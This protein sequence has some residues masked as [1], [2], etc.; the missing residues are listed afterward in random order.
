MALA[1]AAASTVAFLPG[2]FDRFVWPKVLCGVLAVAVGFCA[3]GEGR[4]P[5]PLVAL[6]GTGVAVM[7][8]AA[9]AGGT[10]VA[11]LLGRWPRY[12]GVP[13]VLLY[14]AMTA[15][16]AHLLGGRDPVRVRVLCRSLTVVAVLIA[17]VAWA[18]TLGAS[19]L[20]RTDVD[21]AGG[22][23]GNATDQG[24]VALMIASVLVLPALGGSRWDIVG[25]VAALSVVAVSG[26]RAVYLA[27][28]V[29]GVVLAIAGR[30]AG[31]TRVLALGAAAVAAV[32]VAVPV[33]RERFLD[34]ATFA[35]RR[36]LWDDSIPLALEHPALGLGPSRYVDLIDA[37][38]GSAWLDVKDASGGPPDSPH[39]WVLQAWNA[40][41]VV[42]AALAVAVAG[43]VVWRGAIRVRE[44]PDDEFRAGALA[45]VLA[46]GVVL[47]THFT[48]AGTTLLACFLAGSLVAVDGASDVT[49]NRAVSVVAG[50]VAPFV[51]L[52]AAAD[53]PLQR[54]VGA[55][56]AGDVTG[57]Q[58][59][60]EL[61]A[62]LRWWDGDVAML[63]AQ[64]MA[65]TIATGDPRSVP[66][67]VEWADR[68]LDSTP[69]TYA[70][71]LA[72]AV[73]LT[74]SQRADEAI[75][76]LDD[77]VERFP[78]R[79]D[80]RVQRAIARAVVGDVT[81]ARS[82]LRAAKALDPDD[83]AV[84]RLQSALADVG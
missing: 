40:G 65:G 59:G 45:A 78:T 22:L 5:R 38:L 19:P 58:D 72:K 75:G 20:G 60:F 69:E 42:L 11:S 53:L 62:G 51:V 54:G 56:A 57:A 47:S 49:V 21:R 6:V 44:T 8:V 16:G 13:V 52:A 66:W 35:V 43:L 33:V 1:F 29:A 41:G 31:T 48:V 23:L 77:L 68:S 34:S 17:V 82:D 64:A 25:V 26:S 50:L 18:E 73:A 24:L 81:G 80:P 28:I 84:R 36:V 71:G 61:A 63:A 74:S 9:V 83:P 27:T 14:V 46:V 79:V 70:S 2:G 12:E 7:A 30:R 3:P 55:A 37:R 67:T 4:L 76:V 15:L 39:L 10:P 32:A